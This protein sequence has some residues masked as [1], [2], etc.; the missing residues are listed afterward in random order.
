MI[1]SVIRRGT[2]ISAVVALG[3]LIGSPLATN[4]VATAEVAAWGGE[5]NQ[6]AAVSSCAYSFA[7]AGLTGTFNCG[8]VYANAPTG[9]CTYVA[10]GL[11]GVCTATLHLATIHGT[12]VWTAQRVANAFILHYTCSHSANTVD[13]SGTL[14][15]QP[16]TGLGSPES[17]PVSFHISHPGTTTGIETIQAASP[18]AFSSTASVRQPTPIRAQYHGTNVN[19]ATGA[20]V[21]VDGYFTFLCDYIGSPG[22]F[23]GT[24]SA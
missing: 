20:L 24:L 23:A 13:G 10:A 16:V 22:T 2:L 19:L 6:D 5:L 18:A 3:V 7:P 1:R 12:V 9:Q 17:V 14:D 4:A 15:F 21:T 8:N 11:T